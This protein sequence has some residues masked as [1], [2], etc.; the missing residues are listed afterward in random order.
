[1]TPHPSTTEPPPAPSAARRPEPRSAPTPSPT[2]DRRRRVWIAAALAA[3]AAVA[4]FAWTQLRSA[5]TSPAD[6]A[7][8]IAVVERRDF[9]HTLRIHG[10]VYA[11]DSRTIA[12]PRL[13]GAPGGQMIITRLAAGGSQVRRGDPLVEFDHQNQI[14]QALDRETEFKDLEEQIK[15]R[16]AEMDAARA[17][18]ETELQQAENAVHSARLEMRK[19][20]VI[21]RIDAEKNSQALAEAEARLQQLKD[22]FQLK[23]TA[24]TAD[25]RI[26]EIR[27]DRARRAMEQAQS[28][29]QRMAI[30]SPMDGLVVLKTMWRSGTMTD[31]QEG[32][33]VNPGFP[34]LEVVNPAAMEVRARVNQADVD[35]L[36]PG[37]PVQVRLDAYP[38]FLLPG[39]LERMAAI[40]LTSG[41][42]SSVRSFAALFSVRG[43]DP[44]LLP[45]LSA[46]VD[47]E[48]RRIPAATVIPRDA[49]Q[50]QGD[51][52]FVRVKRGLAWE[53]RPITI[54]AMSDIEVAVA[55]GLDQG[56]QVQRHIYIEQ[57]LPTPSQE[58]ARR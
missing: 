32:D 9:V 54:A 15:R 1:M 52:A 58:A 4:W 10:T 5:A 49:V 23:R 41:M 46:A 31:V 55:S 17:R 47:V 53:R 22:T 25:L 29:T 42:S 26:L 30:T 39:R 43:A 34:V 38:D 35:D 2:P 12:V 36:R 48:L 27:R 40:G 56:A 51:Q 6:A 37:L 7:A 11:T 14:R 21:S 13:A 24:A 3:A 57:K 19:N 33:Q 44:R 20:E 16:R 18:D 45:D 28:N 8:R 50:F